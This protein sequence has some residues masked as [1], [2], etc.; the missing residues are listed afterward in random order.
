MGIFARFVP[1]EKPAF[2]P[3]VGRNE[4]GPGSKQL[5]QITASKHVVAFSTACVGSALARTPWETCKTYMQLRD[6]F[7][8]GQKNR[9]ALGFFQGE[10]RRHAGSEGANLSLMRQSLFRG[11]VPSMVITPLIGLRFGTYVTVA[12]GFK[13]SLWK[14][15]VMTVDAFFSGIVTGYIE[16]AVGTPLE[17]WKTRRQLSLLPGEY[18]TRM[19]A[20]TEFVPVEYNA[21]SVA[22]FRNIVQQE[23]YSPFL[24]S[25]LVTGARNAVFCSTF[26]IMWKKI[27]LDAYEVLEFEGRPNRGTYEKEPISVPLVAMVASGFATFMSHPFDT[28]KTYVEAHRI[29]QK[30]VAVL[31]QSSEYQFKFARNLFTVRRWLNPFS[32]VGHQARSV[33]LVAWH[34]RGLGPRLCANVIGAGVFFGLYENVWRAM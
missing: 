23:G 18:A 12:S 24:R 2:A 29:S 31:K 3:F 5:L 1:V 21:G 6:S 22:L 34:L 10:L 33:Y 9:T 4:D 8:C 26:F 28:L 17:F 30:N 13:E 16:A 7:L 32:D 20:K 14:R 27:I 25:F 15:R 19:K 11:A